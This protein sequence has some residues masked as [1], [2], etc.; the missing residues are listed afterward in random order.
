MTGTLPR[1]W[2]V[3]LVATRIGAQSSA[4]QQPLSTSDAHPDD[5]TEKYECDS[6][7][8]GAAAAAAAHGSAMDAT[9][10]E[11]EPERAGDPT[12]TAAAGGAESAPTSVSERERQALS[13]W[14]AFMKAETAAIAAKHPELDRDRVVRLAAARAAQRRAD[15]SAASVTTNAADSAA[16]LP[17][18]T[19]VVDGPGAD[20]VRLSNDTDTRSVQ[21]G[22]VNE[23]AMGHEQALASETTVP[24]TTTVCARNRPQDRP[25]LVTPSS[26]L[27]PPPWCCAALKARLGLPPILAPAG[28]CRGVPGAVGRARARLLTPPLTLCVPFSSASS[29]PSLCLDCASGGARGLS[30]RLPQVE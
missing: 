20:A 13:Q 1:L 26:F 5:R 30:G 4:W 10:S 16:G 15:E 2:P 28:S 6:A 21:D 24:A 23:P 29:L 8:C 17:Q 14:A 7:G 22:I 19:P 9:L 25:R 12:K 11:S 18:A 27:L 3:L